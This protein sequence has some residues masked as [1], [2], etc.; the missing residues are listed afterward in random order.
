MECAT[1]MDNKDKDTFIIELQNLL[2][3]L[4][5]PPVDKIGLLEKI[6]SL[7]NDYGYTD[8]DIGKAFQ[9]YHNHNDYGEL[10]G[11]I[12]AGEN[13]RAVFK[14]ISRVRF[15]T[16]GDVSNK[17]NINN[18]HISNILADLKEKGLVEC[19]NPQAKRGRL[20][21]TT[22]LGKAILPLLRL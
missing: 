10:I 3:D 19:I 2:G 15:I 6:T 11:W 14:E 13:R 18:N 20:Y 1:L 9:D 5:H 22:D 4:N 21:C 17:T 7:C 8:I 12:Y 16:P